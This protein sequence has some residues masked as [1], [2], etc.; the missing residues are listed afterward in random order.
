[1]KTLRSNMG[2][3]ASMKKSWNGFIS[4]PCFM[5]SRTII[6]VQSG[7]E[8]FSRINNS[9]F[10]QKGLRKSLTGNFGNH[11]NNELLPYGQ[12]VMATN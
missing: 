2:Q 10:Y 7:G 4:I 5:K 9:S 1:M 8:Y 6:L 11:I 3:E 12:I